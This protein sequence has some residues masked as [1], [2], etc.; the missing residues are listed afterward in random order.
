MTGILCEDQCTFLT[1]SHSVHL[2]MRNVSDIIVEKTRIQILYIITFFLENCAFYE[3][4]WK[5]TV[6]LGRLQMVI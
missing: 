1:I 4:M 5:S 3:M 6:G 2:R